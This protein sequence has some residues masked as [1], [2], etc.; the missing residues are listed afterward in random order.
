MKM[1]RILSPSATVVDEPEGKELMQRAEQ[2]LRAKYDISYGSHANGKRN[3][4][5]GTAEERAA[6][7]MEA[8]TDPTVFGI[9]STQGGNNSNDLLD[10]LITKR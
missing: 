8:F 4:L 5:S 7:I 9:L 2:L 6:D 1:I 3:Y 10:L